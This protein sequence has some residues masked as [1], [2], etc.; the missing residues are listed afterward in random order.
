MYTFVRYLVKIFF[1]IFYRVK[2]YG[3]ENI[4]EE[5]GYLLCANHVTGMD[6]FYIG[7]QLKRRVHWMAKSE[8]FDIPVLSG[9][10]K[11]FGA[12]PL[13]RGKADLKAAKSTLEYLEQ[14]EIVGIF[15]QGTRTFNKDISKIKPK[16]GVAK[17][18]AESGKPIFP[19][20]IDGRARIFSKV[21]IVYGKPFYL[22]VEEGKKYT[23]VEYLEMSQKIM[24][25]IYKMIEDVK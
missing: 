19:V 4:P 21:N 22:D 9:I 23:K 3:L 10:I 7:V 5:G 1:K 14:G 11:W 12:Y 17:F 15:P 13:T 25:N 16:Q 6:M 18:A 20:G 8:L 24:D 2:Y